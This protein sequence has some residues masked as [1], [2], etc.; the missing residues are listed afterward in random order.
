MHP[1]AHRRGRALSRA[2][3]NHLKSILVP[4]TALLLLAPVVAAVP[5]E[6][7]GPGVEG[8]LAMA[9]EPATLAEAWATATILTPL[10]APASGILRLEGTASAQE[11]YLLR[12][13]EVRV[14]GAVLGVAEGLDEWAFDL[15]TTD[16]VDGEH[17][18][19]VLA[20]G[21]PELSPHLLWWG[22]A[23]SATL[24]TQNGL[25][26]AVLVERAV[27]VSGHDVQSWSHQLDR[28]YTG[29]RVTLL[30]VP[31]DATSALAGQAIATHQG[32]D[33]EGPRTWIVTGGATGEPRYA[34]DGPEGG[35]V[36]DPGV[37]TLTSA[38][39]GKGTVVLRVEAMPA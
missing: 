5:D 9:P 7:G 26:R 37:L 34:R 10:A 22:E 20:Y 13:I 33:D 12:K 30:F 36:S 19:D 28:A 31:A 24:T 23:T 16:L 3:G 8:L 17:R 14:D 21:A 38:F 6:L 18:L 15:D 1:R 2:G 32:V 39:A 27:A 25:P 29:L 35:G 11:G 4:A